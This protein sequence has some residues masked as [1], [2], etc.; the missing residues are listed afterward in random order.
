MNQFYST[1]ATSISLPHGFVN[2]GVWIREVKLRQLN[3]YDVKYSQDTKELPLPI[4][5]SKLLQRVIIFERK[6]SDLSDKEEQL[7]R[8]LT[9]G[10]RIYLM[11]E[12]CGFTF[13]DKLQLNA[14]NIGNTIDDHQPLKDHLTPQL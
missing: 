4:R 8:Y 7:V 1:D 6:S 9:V 5:V 12:L 3:G 2:D 10:D 13:G 11:L 14:N